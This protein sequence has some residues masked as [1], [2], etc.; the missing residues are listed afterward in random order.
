MTTRFNRDNRRSFLIS[1]L[2]PNFIF[3]LSSS[4]SSF[5]F[6]FSHPPSAF[7]SPALP[8]LPPPHHQT[9]K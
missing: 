4:F 2:P 9:D 1:P 7:A 3:N 8:A 6:D 5:Q